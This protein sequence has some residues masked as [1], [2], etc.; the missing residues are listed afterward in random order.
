MPTMRSTSA[1]RRAISVAEMTPCAF[2]ASLNCAP[3][4][5][6]GLSAFMALCMTT[7]MSFQR[8]AASCLSESPTMLRPLKI[9]LPLV[10]P[11]GGASSWAIANSNVDLPQPDSP[12]IPMNSPASR[13]KLTSSTART[14]PRSIAYSTVRPRTSS[15]GR[16][17]NPAKPRFCSA[18]VLDT[19]PPHGAQGG[20]ADLVEGVV[21]QREGG[22]ER[23]DA[24]PRCDRPP[25]LAGL[26]RLVVFG[27][28]QHRPP[29]QRVGVA[30]ADE[31]QAGRE[32]QRVQG[33]AQED[34]DD[35]RG[36]GRD[37]LHNDDVRLALATHLRRL[38]EVSVSQG[39]C[40]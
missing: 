34:R 8:S 28:V 3:I 1:D 38:E 7:D 26:Q 31:L 23:G 2:M 30:E 33:A 10:M 36:H 32:Q 6:T 39:Q 13:S 19:N 22:A 17:V 12:T 5:F 20:I 35:E 11:A 24:S 40:L 29:A 16:V 21:E 37:D 9:T 18:C 25:V 4:D 15:M 27:P 14:R